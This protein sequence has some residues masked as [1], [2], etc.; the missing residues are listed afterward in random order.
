MDLSHVGPEAALPFPSFT[1]RLRAQTLP[2]LPALA[3]T[4]LLLPQGWQEDG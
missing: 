1:R 4:T 3:N 2:G